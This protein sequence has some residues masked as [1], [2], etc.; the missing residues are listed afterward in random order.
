V[1]IE[2]RE[3][4]DDQDGYIFAPGPGSETDCRA[5]FRKAFR[6]AATKAGLNPDLVTPH[7]MRHTA[8]TRLIKVGV[9][10]PT[11]Q[12]VSGHKTLAMV[13]RYNH[14]AGLHIDAATEK[15]SFSNSDV[16]TPELHAATNK[17]AS[18][19]R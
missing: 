6:R 7:V 8:I 14:V 17:V 11:V 3:T 10:L 1:L 5:S 13:L 16:V 18:L 19:K 15:L 9:D 4:R 2:I 12:K